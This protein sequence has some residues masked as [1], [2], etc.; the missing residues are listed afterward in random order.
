VTSFGVLTRWL[1]LLWKSLLRSSFNAFTLQ[2]RPTGT[3]PALPVPPS[4]VTSRPQV[5]TYPTLLESLAHL[6]PKQ[7]DTFHRLQAAVINLVWGHDAHPGCSGTGH[8][9]VP[10]AWPLAVQVK[11]RIRGLPVSVAGDLGSSTTLC[12]QTLYEQL[13]AMP[14]VVPTL[15]P[16]HVSLE[17]H[18]SRTHCTPVP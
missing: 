8:P 17:F 14:P 13:P 1:R 12:C 15:A 9:T 2:S 3:A 4:F 11:G 18:T 16:V 5:T 6:P 10:P 7:V